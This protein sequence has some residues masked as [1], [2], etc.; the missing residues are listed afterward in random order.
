MPFIQKQFNA[1][2]FTRWKDYDRCPAFAKY[3]HLDKLDQGPKHPAM[4]RGADIA[5]ETDQWFK[6][7]RR[8]MPKE[9]KPL[10]PIYKALKKDKT[11]Q[12]ESSWGFTRDWEPCGVTDWN[13]CW[14]RVKVDILTTAD[15]ARVLNLYD[16]KTGKFSEAAAFD[17]GMQLNLYA[18]AGTVMY[19]TAELINTQLLF[20]DLGIV[21]P[22]EGPKPYTR[23]QA[24]GEIK[25]WEKRVKPMFNDRRFAPT[26]GDYCRWCPYS[27]AKGGP[28]KY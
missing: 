25:A 15:G 19:P 27:K 2:S 18:A 3:K 14:L 10:E 5:D 23:Q 26:P 13:R 21:H 11:V 1:W 28:C 22:K 24:Q 16:S 7:T 6:G 12:T 8:V 20:S 4:Q 9:L 17:Y